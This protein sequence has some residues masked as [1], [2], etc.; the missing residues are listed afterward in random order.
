[1]CGVQIIYWVA[2][3]IVDDKY[4]PVNYRYRSGTLAAR[5]VLEQFVS[6]I[7]RRPRLKFCT[8]PRPARAL[9]S[10]PPRGSEICMRMDAMLERH[11]GVI[12]SLRV[13]HIEYLWI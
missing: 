9:S 4:I 13:T 3:K 1:M 8:S 2:G 7:P 11:W 6:L 5:F 12:T 10:G